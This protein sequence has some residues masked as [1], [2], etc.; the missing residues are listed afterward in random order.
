MMLLTE[1]RFIKDFPGY[2]IYVG[3]TG[4]NTLQNL[5]V[6]RLNA[7]GDVDLTCAARAEFT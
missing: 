1:G 2:V 4:A 5:R 7:D 3:K 6:Y